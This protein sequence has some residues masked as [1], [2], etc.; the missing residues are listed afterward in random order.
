MAWKEANSKERVA[1]VAG[2]ENI[3]GLTVDDA[4][5]LTADCTTAAIACIVATAAQAA[6]SVMTKG[7]GFQAGPEQ[8]RRL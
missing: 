7:K 3:G 2:G 1:A 8:Q 5:E 6:G 4:G